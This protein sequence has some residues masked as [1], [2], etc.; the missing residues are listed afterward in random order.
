M[1]TPMSAFAVI[2]SRHG[3]DPSD[4]EAVDRFFDESAP[5]LP[6]EER[7]AIFAALL[8]ADGK[9][10]S[11]RR[12]HYAKTQ[13]DA[14]FRDDATIEVPQRAVNPRLEPVEELENERQRL[15]DRAAT[16]QR[17]FLDR[18][19]ADDRLML[20]LLYRRREKLLHALRAELTAAGITGVE[21][22]DLIGHISDA[23]DFGLTDDSHPTQSEEEVGTGLKAPK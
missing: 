12:R 22:A 7:E 10:D 11:P 6:P 17:S 8:A 1:P 4:E 2:A 3:V 20:K 13:A 15:S 23:S 21:G 18:L 9:G 14:S 5:E 19:P 16:I